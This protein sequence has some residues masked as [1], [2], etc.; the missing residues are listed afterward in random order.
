VVALAWLGHETVESETANL[1]TRI[2]LALR[3]ATS[4]E[5]PAGP[6]WLLN[7]FQ[8]MT[9]RGSVTVLAFIV[10]FTAAL[11]RLDSRRAAAAFPATASAGAWAIGN[12]VK[13][14]VDRP[15]PSIVSHLAEVHDASLPGGH[16]T[17]STAT[18]PALALLAAA[19]VNT[20]GRAQFFYGLAFFLAFVIG[21]SSPTTAPR[22]RIRMKA[23]QNRMVLSTADQ[24]CGAST[25]SSRP[26]KRI[27]APV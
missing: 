3:N 27:A 5:L 9:S 11:L 19:L 2:L 10:F 1:D 13:N 6:H 8:N 20:P 15:R 21:A 24:K 4:P 7:Y 12:L 23:A 14:V 25:I 26:P 17:V 22:G 18:Y 16:T